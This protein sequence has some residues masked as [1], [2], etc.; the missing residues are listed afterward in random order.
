MF[1]ELDGIDKVYTTL[2]PTLRAIQGEG[3]G[4]GV[5]PLLAHV[6][7]ESRVDTIL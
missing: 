5:S 4:E 6:E 7:T 1:D 2:C 3:E